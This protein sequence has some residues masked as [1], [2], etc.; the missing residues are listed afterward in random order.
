M[1][2]GEFMNRIKE[3]RKERGLSLEQ[4]S[5]ELGKRD[6]YISSSSLSKYERGV[7]NPKIENWIA[8]ANYF[9]VSISYLQGKSNDKNP[10]NNDNLKAIRN[11]RNLQEYQNTIQD[12]EDFDD[13][14]IDNEL[15]TLIGSMVKTFNTNLYFLLPEKNINDAEKVAITG[16]YYSINNLMVSLNKYIG[17]SNLISADK[18]LSEVETSHLKT[19]LYLNAI[20]IFKNAKESIDEVNNKTNDELI[21]WIDSI[22][23]ND[24]L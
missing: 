16:L 13:S 6:C 20:K 10:I 1:K 22:N 2:G 23:S 7:R 15:K 5:H 12:L 9:A 21:K 17:R 18:K 14:H 3:L 11:Y 4:L 24:L 8:L 19:L